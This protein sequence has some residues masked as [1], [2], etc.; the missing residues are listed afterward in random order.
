[1]TPLK[2]PKIFKSR[3]GLQLRSSNRLKMLCFIH[4]SPICIKYNMEKN[5]YLLLFIFKHVF[6]INKS[7]QEIP[8]YHCRLML[9]FMLITCFLSM[10]V[11]NTATTAMMI[12]IAQA[13]IVQL[14]ETKHKHLKE[15]KHF[16][17]LI[18]K[19]GLSCDFIDRLS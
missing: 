3:L 4:V 6:L 7:V 14:M 12:P 13:V 5:S 17:L 8:L 18:S 2:F 15:G 10:W 11:S 19:F 1:M 9:G 16:K